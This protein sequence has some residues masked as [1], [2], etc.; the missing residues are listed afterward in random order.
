MKTP[1]PPIAARIQHLLPGLNPIPANPPVN[2]RVFTRSFNM[3]N[4]VIGVYDD[5]SHA[6]NALNELLASGFSRSEVQLSPSENSSAAR[7]SYLSDNSRTDDA[8]GGSGIGN[9]FK[10]LFGGG[11][12]NKH[13]DVYSEAVRRGSYMLTV[14][15]DSDEQR[16][17][18]AD[19]MNRYNPVDI[20]ERSS[21]WRSKGWSQYDSSA[22]A[23]SD[24]EIE[25]ERTFTVS[26][27][28]EQPPAQ[29]MNSGGTLEGEATIPVIQEELKVG[30]RE[31]QRGGVRVFQR[32]VETP[33]HES[34]QL[35][36]EHVKV[37]R[38]PVNQPATEADMAAFKEGSLELRE[39]AEEAVVGKTARVVEE[40]TIGK[41]VT[42]RTEAIDDTVRRTDVQ[43]EQLGTQGSM[44]TTTDDSHFRTHWQTAYGQSGGRYEDYAPAYQ[45]GS[46]L[47]GNERYK[48][49]QWNEIE[50]EARLDWESRNAG[51]PWEKSKDAVRFGWEK[52]KR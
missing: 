23:Y 40:V 8:G 12:E 26:P 4:T 34:V 35:R 44:G 11:Q 19:I 5:Y 25:Q 51:S 14:N 49:H 50:P 15:A 1:S 20:D 48:G 32:V 46:T 36:E 47:G 22:P 45:Y 41:E 33:V 38:H 21:H 27:Q 24:A 16:D 9:F 30:K 31:V 7:Q 13:A 29:Q 37:E 28:N 52:I 42:E 6:Q 43:V 3:A 10:S 2:N 18:A 39:T 17:Q